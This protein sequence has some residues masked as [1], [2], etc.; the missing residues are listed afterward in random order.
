MEINT[1]RQKIIFCPKLYGFI[2]PVVMTKQT[3]RWC[4]ITCV[5]ELLEEKSLDF[6]KE[7]LIIGEKL[8]EIFGINMLPSVIANNASAIYDSAEVC[9]RIKYYFNRTPPEI[10]QSEVRFYMTFVELEKFSVPLMI[11]MAEFIERPNRESLLT[12]KNTIKK[13]AEIFAKRIH[14][15][16]IS[17]THFCQNIQYLQ[18]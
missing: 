13:F 8:E 17:H 14:G 16:Y 6:P 15:G 2:A 9:V 1:F 4:Q 10:A 3:Y 5:T 11:N 7:L 18:S 12:I